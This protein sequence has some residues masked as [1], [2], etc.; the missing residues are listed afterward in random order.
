VQQLMPINGLTTRGDLM[1][2]EII[3]QFCGEKK[4]F[5]RSRHMTVMHAG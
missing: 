4:T 5:R 3:L 2:E 1:S